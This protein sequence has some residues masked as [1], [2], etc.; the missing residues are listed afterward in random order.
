MAGPELPWSRIHI[1]YAG[2]FLRKMFLVTVDAHSKWID[3]HMMSCSTSLATVS[4]LRETF[5]MFGIPKVV[6]L[7]NGPCFSSSEFQS[8]ME[9]NGIIHRRVAP[10]HPSSNGLAER[11]VQTIKSGLKKLSGPIK[12]R[13]QRFLFSYRITLQSV[14]GK[15]PA[16]L[17][18][19]RSLRSQLDL[20]HPDPSKQVLQK[21][22]SVEDR[23][24][25]VSRSFKPGDP[26]F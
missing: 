5:S 16:M 1:D 6:V 2:P 10:Y 24:T 9:E 21:Q 20:I 7:D 17:M 8:F 25:R 12:T 15:S 19:G 23:R 18:F 13:L 4:K 14:T 26:V 3:V 11:A 22:M